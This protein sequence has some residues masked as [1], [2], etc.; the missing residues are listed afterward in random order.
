MTF[1]FLY[2]G[3]ADPLTVPAAGETVTLDKWYRPASEP[4]RKVVAIAAIVGATTFAPPFVPDSAAVTLDRWYQPASE[5]V[6]TSV[7]LLL[8]GG[9]TVAP[10]FVPDSAAV[11]MDRWYQPASEPVR[12]VPAAQQQAT[13]FVPVVEVPAPSMDSWY[14]PASEPVQ[15]VP[16]AIQQASDFKMP[17]TPAPEVVLRE[18]AARIH[19]VAQPISLIL[20][21]NLASRRVAEK[22]GATVERETD[23]RQWR[24]LVYR[25]P[26]VD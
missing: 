10:P 4:V 16:A 7:P 24:V 12:T 20:P 22:N 26:P 9:M 8:E 18:H 21:E 2:Q 17:F 14:Q 23:F 25:Y 1:R 3:I 5:P 19:G 15:T 6:R 13:T 11:T